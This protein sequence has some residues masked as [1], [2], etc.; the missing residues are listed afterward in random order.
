MISGDITGEKTKMLAGG[1]YNPNDPQLVLLRQRA[2]LL[3]HRHNESPN[4]AQRQNILAELVPAIGSDAEVEP[5]FF[6]DY[7]EN[8]STGKKFY[9]N[10]GCVIL[11]CN[12]VVIG[13]NVMFGPGVN[14]YSVN[15]PMQAAERATG[16]E[17]TAPVHIGNNVWL[18]GGVI[19]CPG[20]TIG[21]NTVVGA[22]SVVVKDLPANVLAAGNPCHVIRPLDSTPGLRVG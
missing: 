3:C 15:H 16:V 11:D 21:D 8:I 19:V 2:K 5:P 14:I 13:D 7:G 12:R 9:M 10:H 17:L 22:G 20:V 18:G 4:V 1:P 6:C